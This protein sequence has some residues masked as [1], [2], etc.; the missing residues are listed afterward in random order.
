MAAMEITPR[1]LR[2][3]EIHSEIRGYSRDEVNDLLERAA[4]A[5]EASNQRVAQMQDR[6]TSVQSESVRTRGLQCQAFR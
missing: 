3:T 5:I 4:M 1:E 2:D 6:L